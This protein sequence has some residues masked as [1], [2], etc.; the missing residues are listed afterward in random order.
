MKKP[1][2]TVIRSNKSTD[3]LSI[4]EVMRRLRGGLLAA[5][6][7]RPADYKPMFEITEIN[8]ELGVVFQR[9]AKVKGGVNL[10]VAEIGAEGQELSSASHRITLKLIPL[11]KGISLTEEEVRS[12]LYQ[13]RG[14][15]K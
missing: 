1:D 14:A 13:G 4:Q 6:V 2:S 11:R 8:V 7:D 5:A 12:P 10:Y 9:S 3:P 15:E